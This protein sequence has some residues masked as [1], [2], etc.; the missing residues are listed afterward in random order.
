MQQCTCK[1][2][3]GRA[4]HKRLRILHRVLI[5]RMS[6]ETEI[7]L[8]KRNHDDGGAFVGIATNDDAWHL[9][10]VRNRGQFGELAAGREYV[11]RFEVP[12]CLL[13]LD[14][15]LTVAVIENHDRRYTV[16]MAKEPLNA[17]QYWSFVVLERERITPCD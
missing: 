15:A 6:A 14:E 4:H 11:Q 9:A 2:Q 10:D 8:K 5:Q 3:T 13:T 12:E 17:D 16:Q 1:T 7:T